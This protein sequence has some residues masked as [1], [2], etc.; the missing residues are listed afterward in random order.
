M[1][2]YAT[3][4]AINIFNFVKTITTLEVIKMTSEKGSN[5]FIY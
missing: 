1:R 5:T 4:F 3:C 2:L